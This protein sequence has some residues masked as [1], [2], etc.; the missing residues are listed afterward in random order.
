MAGKNVQ[1]GCLR[2]AKV[3]SC[4][5]LVA[6]WVFLKHVLFPACRPPAGG[7][8]GSP[9]GFTSHHWSWT[10]HRCWADSR[11]ATL[12]DRCLDGLCNS[13]RRA[14]LPVHEITLAAL[15]AETLGMRIIPSHGVCG[16][17]DKRI[18]RL[19]SALHVSIHRRRVSGRVVQLIAGHLSF[20]ANASR[21]ALS[22]LD[23]VFKITAKH[24]ISCGIPW[25]S[26]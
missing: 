21:G 14:G 4:A 16:N 1:G 7:L 2:G 26:F 6:H 23:S 13:F 19:R 11:G 15:L 25:D 9:V 3:V 17:T 24:L 10:A 22:L 8:C 5:T 18:F 12:T 20:G